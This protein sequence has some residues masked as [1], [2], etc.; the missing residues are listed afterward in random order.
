MTGAV[1]GRLQGSEDARVKE[2]ADFSVKVSAWGLGTSLDG[3]MRDGVFQAIAGAPGARAFDPA[4]VSPSLAEAREVEREL[5]LPIVEHFTSRQTDLE[6]HRGRVRAAENALHATEARLAS[7]KKTARR[8]GIAEKIGLA[9]L[10]GGIVT[11]AATG[12]LLALPVAIASTAVFVFGFG[13]ADKARQAQKPTK[14]QMQMLKEEREQAAGMVLSLEKELGIQRSAFEKVRACLH[15]LQ[16]D[17][18]A[19]AVRPAPRCADPVKVEED[20]VCVGGVSLPRRGRG[21]IAGGKAA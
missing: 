10:A 14:E 5:L 18:I 1:M 21:R 4:D 9:G 6:R 17:E 15:A 20:V 16:L 11:L 2:L 12:A 19:G 7:E 13:V 3:Q 8:K